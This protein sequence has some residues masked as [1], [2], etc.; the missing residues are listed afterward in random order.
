MLREGWD[1]RNVTTIVPLRALSAKNRVLG[2]QVLGRGLRRI[3]PPVGGAAEIVTV[4]EH[5]F[6]ARFYREE[7]AAEG[8]D[9]DVTEVSRVPKT[10]VSIYPDE[11]RKDVAALDIP[12]PQITAGAVNTAT[13]GEIDFDEV[14]KAFKRL[15]L[16]PLPLE[17]AKDGHLD[18]E[19]R[20]LV[21]GEILEKMKIHLPLLRTGVGAVSY[22]VKELEMVAH[23][24]G[25]HAKLA[26][27]LGRFW[28]ETLFDR[29]TT[30]SDPALVARLGDGAARE[31]TRAVFVP[32]L[33]RKTT[34]AQQR[35]AAAPPV[36]PA[37][38]RPFQATDSETHPVKTARR[39]LFNLVPCNRRLEAAFTD[40]LER[41]ADVAAF[42]KNAGPQCLRIDYLDTN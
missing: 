12:V 36:S 40:F 37:A 1:V 20:H 11:A 32:L 9:I 3:T 16:P 6:F 24:R 31:C 19:G 10:T 18:Y 13:L 27:L 23:L 38:W 30:L 39:T 17:K 29:Q 42:V 33:R 14:K 28:T 7:L 26:P 25:T 8:V 41:A 15:G 5:E 35:V 4:V 21:T 2:E 34:L 22:F